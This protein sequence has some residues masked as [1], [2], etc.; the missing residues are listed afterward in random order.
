MKEK[1]RHQAGRIPGEEKESLCLPGQRRA[2]DLVV[3]QDTAGIANPE[4]GL[5]LAVAM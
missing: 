2:A 4:L 1:A 3:D 5:L